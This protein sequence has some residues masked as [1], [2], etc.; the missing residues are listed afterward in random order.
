MHITTVSLSHLR[1]DPPIS[2]TACFFL[3]SQQLFRS[4]GA[5][6]R[7]RPWRSSRPR[8]HGGGGA[9]AC[10]LGRDRAPDVLETEPRWRSGVHTRSHPLASSGILHALPAP[11]SVLHA[12]LSRCPPCVRSLP[13]RTTANC[14]CMMGKKKGK[15]E[16]VCNNQWQ[17]GTFCKTLEACQ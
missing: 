6:R 17:V 3:L 11:S 1:V 16:P 12:A 8:P 5:R 9:R 15:N 13:M 2:L 7:P 14:S 10:P 4:L